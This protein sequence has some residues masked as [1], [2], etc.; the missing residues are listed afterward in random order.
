[1]LMDPD[2]TQLNGFFFFKKKALLLHHSN[3]SG[4]HICFSKIVNNFELFK[5]FVVRKK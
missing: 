3:L 1:M 2:E 4:G 5:N